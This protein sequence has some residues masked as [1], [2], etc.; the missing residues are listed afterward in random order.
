MPRLT[1]DNVPETLKLR[2]KLWCI[3]KGS[4]MR[5]EI[6]KYIEATLAKTEAK[7]AKK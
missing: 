2:F 5:E 6:V 1:I 3:S 4:S 7:A